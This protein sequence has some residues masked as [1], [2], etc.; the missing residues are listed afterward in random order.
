MSID[1][2]PSPNYYNDIWVP[3]SLKSPVLLQI[4]IYTAACYRSELQKIPASQSPI[5]LKLKSKS[6]EILNGLLR[7]QRHSTCDEAIAAVVYLI[8]NEWYWGTSQ[9]VQAHIRGLQEMVRLRGGI[10]TE[11]HPFL[12]QMIIL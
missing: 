10:S 2:E 3:W 7:D 11:I 8:T 6:I 4:A 9:N 1:G 5:S 12:K